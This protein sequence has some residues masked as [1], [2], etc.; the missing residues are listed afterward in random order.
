MK[1][2]T[3]LFLIL[4]VMASM[5]TI[6]SCN[7][8]KKLPEKITV[9]GQVTYEN[10]DAAEGVAVEVISSYLMAIPT[11]VDL[12][13]YTNQDGRYIVE[14]E[15]QE[16][17]TYSIRFNV[18]KDGCQYYYQDALTKWEANQV[19]DVVLKKAEE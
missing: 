8:D 16:S 14:F 17:L 3:K 15:P 9:N 5:L 7:K 1:K 12:P 19:C 4:L 18:T 2:T 13:V 6:T 10:G 11:P